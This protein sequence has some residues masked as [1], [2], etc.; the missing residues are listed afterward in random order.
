M[1]EGSQDADPPRKKPGVFAIAFSVIAAAFGVQT[2]ANRRRDFDADS[3]LPYILGGLLFTIVFVLV[4][5][6][7]V[8]LVL[9]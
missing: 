5:I 1:N 4:L 6:G 9:A 7:I 3:P 2:D 8:N